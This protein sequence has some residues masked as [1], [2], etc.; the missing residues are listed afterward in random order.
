MPY[1][2]RDFAVKLGD[3]LLASSILAASSC[4][5]LVSDPV[6]HDSG[7]PVNGGPSVGDSE[8]DSSPDVPAES[9]SNGSA[10]DGGSPDVAS[11]RG[12]AGTE[13]SSSIGADTGIATC[14]GQSAPWSAGAGLNP[15]GPPAW[16]ATASSTF[17]STNPSLSTTPTMAFDRNQSTRWSSGQAQQGNEWFRIDLGQTTKLSQVLVF[18][19]SADATDYPVSYTLGLSTDDATYTTVAMGSGAAPTTAICFAQ[20]SARYV[21]ISQTGTAPIAWWSIDEITI[22][23]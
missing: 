14:P 11:A 15:Q 19:F 1:P 8:V 6:A 3:T 17:T 5:P 12:D 20:Q 7:P 13:T 9:G 4:G 16:N 22:V 2:M 21:K 23:N 18:V 10:D